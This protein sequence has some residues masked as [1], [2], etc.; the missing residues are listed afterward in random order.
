MV[1]YRAECLRK[2]AVYCPVWEQVLECDMVT[3]QD[4]ER[5]FAI[6]NLKLNG[7]INRAQFDFYKPELVMNMKLMEK[8]MRN[9]LAK[10]SNNPLEV[11]H[12]I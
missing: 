12:G 4:I 11:N 7:V 9:T 8:V 2:W 5:A 10:K 6:A 3:N 1:V